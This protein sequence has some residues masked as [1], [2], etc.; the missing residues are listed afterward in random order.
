[1]KHLAVLGLGGVGGYLGGMLAKHYEKNPNVTISFICR[2]DH[3]Q[4]IEEHGLH[5][6]T[7]SLDFVAKPNHATDK[8]ESIKPIDFLFCCTKTYGLESALHSIKTCVH[9]NTIFIPLLNGV[10]SFEHIKKI[11]PDNPVWNA[12]IYIVSRKI[13][14]GEIVVSGIEPKFFFGT[15]SK[16]SEAL[17][18][19]HN[20]MHEAAIPSIYTIEIVKEMWEKFFFISPVASLTSWLNQNIGEFRQHTNHVETLR[21]LINELKSVADKLN[22]PVDANIV[23]IVLD[24]VFFLPPE[25]TTSMHSDFIN[26]NET[27]LESLTGYVVHLAKKH[28]LTL[29]TYEKIYQDLLLRN[30]SSE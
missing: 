4:Q 30:H 22:I 28:Q 21:L 2:G 23:N 19:F 20:L 3:L 7:P 16:A 13:A 1:M 9:R 27:E 8:P 25:T 29:P 12:C 6:K 11:F 15:D 10:D 14:P 5:V 24:R 18:N 17:S 26:K